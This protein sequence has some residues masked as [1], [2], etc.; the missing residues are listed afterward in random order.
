MSQKLEDTKKGLPSNESIIQD[1]T[2][3]LKL[4]E[5]K[6]SSDFQEPTMASD[7]TCTSETGNTINRCK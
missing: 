2:K 4:A 5:E 3:D 7:S 6:E 1:L